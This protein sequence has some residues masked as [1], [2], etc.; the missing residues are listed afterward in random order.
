MQT[1][2]L[3]TLMSAPPLNDVGACRRALENLRAARGIVDARELEI[4]RRLDELAAEHPAIYPDDEV[5]K[6]TKSSINRAGRLRRRQDACDKIPQLAAALR[7]GATTGDRVESVARAMGGLDELEQ[8]TLCSRGDE[9]ARAAS[10]LNDG[11]FRRTLA[12]IVRSVRR[13]DG[14]GELE[15]QRR[16]TELRWWTDANGMWVIHGRYDP[17]NG[18]L[19]EGRIG[20]TIERLFHSAAPATAPDDP[21]DRHRHLAAAALLDLTQRTGTGGAPDVTIV[22]DERTLREGKPHATSIIDIGLGKFGLPIET[23]RRWACSGEITPVISSADGHRL[24]LGR[25]ARIANDHQR[26]ALRVLYRGC[27]LC[28]EPFELCKVHH[29]GWYGWDQPTD[30]DN[31]LPLCHR[32]HDMVHEGGWKLRL[33]KDRTLHVTSPTGEMTTHDP[34]RVWTT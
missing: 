9:V 20:N 29:V 1:D 31:L 19:L 34:P 5:S 13:D 15:R 22:V 16:A 8:A 14:L 26:R 10:S 11:D 6:S 27:A 25:S 21:R 3:R 32:H 17:V 18:A 12:R 30:I 4:L 28:A 24:L 23:I 2:R 33:A 7:A